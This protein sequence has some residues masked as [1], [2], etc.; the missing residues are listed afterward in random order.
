VIVL[1]AIGAAVAF[2]PSW[3]SFVLRTAF[4]SLPPVTAG[5][6]FANPAP[7][8]AG[9]VA[10]MVLLAVVVGAAAFWRPL[11]LGAALAGGAII[12]MV[13]QAVSAIVQVS[14]PT[15]PAQLGY[16]QAQANAAGLTITNGLTPMFWVYCAFLGTM[17]LL[18]A[19]ML[20]TPDSAPR[21]ASYY[22]GLP[23]HGQPYPGQPYPG[24]PY[25]GQANWSSMPGPSDA[26]APA[27]GSSGM[28]SHPAPLQ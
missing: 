18:V 1:A 11:R 26:A 15:S 20:L 4:G 10:V 9:D 16:S 14:E 5:N 19:W 6:A 23:P 27:T 21:P 2:A 3:D 8:I 22:P 24:Q 13:A 17:I 28:P 12:P 7:V 25:P